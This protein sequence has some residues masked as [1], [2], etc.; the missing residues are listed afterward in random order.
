M[1][2]RSWRRPNENVGDM[3]DHH[4]FRTMGLP[5]LFFSCG[6]WE[7]YHQRSDTPE[8]LNYEKM[9]RIAA[10][11]TEVTLACAGC[12]LPKTTGD[13]DTV[14]FEIAL[15]ER[16]FGAL[17]PVMLRMV[18][19]PKLQGRADLDTLVSRLVGMGL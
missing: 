9:A 13:V 8:K 10:L 7:H 19:V 4:V 17:L 18:G 5:Y 12:D 14:A 11:L 3:S 15:L 2:C 6:R 1:R 16:A